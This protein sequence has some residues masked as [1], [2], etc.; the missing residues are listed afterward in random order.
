MVYR[1]LDEVER[2][3]SLIKEQEKFGLELAKTYDQNMEIVETV[4]NNLRLLDTSLQNKP[5]VEN[6]PHLILGNV[7]KTLVKLV[8]DYEQRLFEDDEVK[9]VLKR[10]YPA[11]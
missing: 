8:N 3:R 6:D 7:S 9:Q 4:C 10:V 1:N 5:V 11:M 2:I